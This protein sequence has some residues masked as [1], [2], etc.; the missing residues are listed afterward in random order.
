MTSTILVLGRNGQVA[1]ELGRLAAPDGHALAFAG[2]EDFDLSAGQDP[3]RLL[4]HH[5]PCAVINAAAY[6]AVDKA[7]SEPEAA[8]G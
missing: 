5:R 1:S 8:S 3:R 4:D 7:E 6:T 2:R